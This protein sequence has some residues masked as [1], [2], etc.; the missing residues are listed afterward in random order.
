MIFGPTVIELHSGR[1]ID[2]ADPHPSSVDLG[3]IAHGLAHTCRYSGQCSRFYSVAEHAVLAAA[4][5]Y[6][7]YPGDAPLSLLALHHDDAE[8][9][10]GDVS[11]PLKGLLPEYRTLEHR[12]QYVIREALGLPVPTDEQYARIKEADDWA[13]LAEA[14]QLLPS[15]GEG[16][17]LHEGSFDPGDDR[18]PPHPLGVS[19]Y[20]AGRM[21]SA[22]HRLLLE[23]WTGVAA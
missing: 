4:Y 12:M 8:A 2:L 6:R 10:L 20:E 5:T 21:W 16:W 1:G 13:L 19:P 15:Q 22:T 9:Y 18:L 14:H 17:T 7:T 3:D 23:E 11:R